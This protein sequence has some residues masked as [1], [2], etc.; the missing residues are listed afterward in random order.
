MKMTACVGISQQTQGVST[1]T[2]LLSHFFLSSGSVFFH[3]QARPGP[4]FENSAGSLI[5]LT[6]S[7]TLVC[8][9]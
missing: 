7:E 3:K 5:Q 1:S 6:A 2:F 9:N 8:H 4:P